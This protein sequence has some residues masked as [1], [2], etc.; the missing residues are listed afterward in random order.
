MGVPERRTRR[1][2]VRLS[3]A[4][5]VLVSSFLR[6]CASSQR[7]KSTGAAFSKSLAWMRKVSYETMSTS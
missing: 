3:S 2:Q 6:R 7:S 4:L 1:R 5:L